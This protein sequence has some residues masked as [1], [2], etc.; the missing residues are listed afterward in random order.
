MRRF[1]VSDMQ[2]IGFLASFFSFCKAVIVS[3]TASCRWL[4]VSGNTLLPL[5]MRQK[6]GYIM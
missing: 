1:V 4:A 5:E 6:D 2:L 3:E